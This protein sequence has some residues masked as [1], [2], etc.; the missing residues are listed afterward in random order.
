L[1]KHLTYVTANRKK[2]HNNLLQNVVNEGMKTRANNSDHRIRSDQHYA[3]ICNPT[4]L[5]VLVPTC[6]G[7]SLPSS[8]SLLD[9]SELLEIHILNDI[10]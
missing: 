6:L 9:P 5:Y 3:L 10:V 8:G 4:L 7:S 1:S 2:N